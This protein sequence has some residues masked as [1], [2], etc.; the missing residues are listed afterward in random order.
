MHRWTKTTV[1]VAAATALGL[2][3]TLP[4][5]ATHRH[6]RAPDAG[7]E[8]EVEVDRPLVTLGDEIELSAKFKVKQDTDD[9]EL[10]DEEAE[11]EEADDDEVGDDEVDDAVPPPVEELPIDDSPVETPVP[12]AALPLTVSFDVDYGDGGPVEVLAPDE[13]EFDDEEFE[14]EV[15]GHHTYAAEGDYTVT[16]T[17]VPDLGEPQTATAEVSV[18]TEPVPYPRPGRFACPEGLVPAAGFADVARTSPHD[19]AVDC[20]VAKGVVKGTAPGTFGPAQRLTRGQMASLL[21]RGIELSG[22][23]LVAGVDSYGDD[24][25]SVHEDNINKLAVAGLVNGTGADSFAP[26]APL[27]RAQLASL[28]VRVYEYTADRVL[29][30][31]LD[32]FVDDAASVHEDNINLAAAAGFAGGTDVRTFA[33]DRDVT[34]E[35]I[36][37]FLMRMLDL[38]TEEG[39]IS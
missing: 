35:Q 23:A 25:S 22:Q 38:L 13:L 18:T 11:D 19:L 31:D 16:V 5:Q 32:Y 28:L 2:T 6:D 10:E 7:V 9:D 21:V 26:D 30:A 17:V 8:L 36:S 37:T 4:A 29:V 3:G 27:T 15:T 24:E 12:G 39:L 34:R 1:V 20:L 14:A 33:P